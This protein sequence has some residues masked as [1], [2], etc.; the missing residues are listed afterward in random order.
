M[1]WD[2]LRHVLALSRHR[3]LSDAARELGV[4]RTTVGRRIQALE[5]RLGVKLF[6]A[7]PEGMVATAAGL[8]LADAAARIEVEVSAVESR[9]EGRD[10]ALIGPL[11]IATID[12]LYECYGDLFTAFAEQHPDV[13]LSVFASDDAVSLRRREADIAIRMQEAPTGTLIGRR[14]AEVEFGAFAA[15]ALVERHRGVPLAE[16]PWLRFEGAD[17]DRGL[18]AWYDRDARGAPVAMRFNSYAVMREAVRSGVGVHY[19]PMFDARRFPELVSLGPSPRPTR[20]L[21]A[22]T[23]QDLRSNS[24]VRAFLDHIAGA[25]PREAP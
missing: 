12:A 6:D 8:E 2:D 15:P 9:V 14:L 7:H 5:T 4:A 23:L 11:R 22:L 25:F 19:L 20:S 10:T 16:L 3:T 18:D 21:W 24:R 1:Q 13:E 17:D